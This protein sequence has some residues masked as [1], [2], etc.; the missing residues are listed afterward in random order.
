MDENKHEV[1]DEEMASL[2]QTLREMLY[3]DDDEGPDFYGDLKDAA[4]NVLRENPGYDFDEWVQT[5]MEQYPAEVVDA[6]GS[7][8]AETYAS[9]SDMWDSEDY[10]D[11]ETGECH[12]FKDWAEYFA[13]DRS[14]ELYTLFAEAKGEIRRLEAR[15]RQKQ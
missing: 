11:T 14:V 13:T 3:E 8:P 5:L 9:L 4:W 1:S 6:I 7:H 12:T 10:E 15:L 2:V